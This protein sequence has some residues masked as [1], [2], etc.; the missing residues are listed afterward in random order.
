MKRRPNQG[1]G[2][3][4][5]A[6]GTLPPRPTTGPTSVG[7]YDRVRKLKRRLKWQPLTSSAISDY[8]L[9]RS[10]NVPGASQSQQSLNSL[11]SHAKPSIK[12]AE[13]IASLQ[14]WSQFL[15]Q[16]LPLS[17]KARSR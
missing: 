1:M 10:G 12:P 6:G 15:N 5:F 2:S 14:E 3:R 4:N 8:S 13:E 17:W 7:Y 16:S 9:R 11:A